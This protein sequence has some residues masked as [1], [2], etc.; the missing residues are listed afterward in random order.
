MNDKQAQLRSLPSV[1]SLLSRSP[2]PDLIQAYSRELVVA[3]IRANI[4]AAR[5]AILQS[6]ADENQR[7]RL[8]RG[9]RRRARKPSA[10]Q[11]SLRH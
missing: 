4:D 5:L 7:R 11:P 3:A 1:D 6:N 10:P 8:D 2:I 9:H